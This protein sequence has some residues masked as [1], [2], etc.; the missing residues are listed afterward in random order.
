MRQWVVHFSSGDSDGGLPPLAQTVI[1]MACRLLFLTGQNAQLMLVTM[2]KN[3]LF[4]A[5][6]R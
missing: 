4:V 3:Y 6:K 1:S 2:L 5:E